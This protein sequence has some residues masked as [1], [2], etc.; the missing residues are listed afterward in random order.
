MEQ[1][2]TGFEPSNHEAAFKAQQNSEAFAQMAHE[3]SQQEN[4]N[5]QE[6]QKPQSSQPKSVS[7]LNAMNMGPKYMSAL[8][9]MLSMAD[10][11]SIETQLP[12]LK[13]T[14]EITPM[15]GQE[16]QAI[17]TAA[18]SPEGF[19][20]K[21][22]ELLFGH[23][24]FKDREFTSYHEFL[25]NLYPPDKSV[26]I[27]ALLTSS[28]MVL[29]TMEKECSE[30]SKT[31]IID[32]TPGELI[33]DDTIEKSWDKPLPPSEYTEV[34]DAI[35]GMLSFEIGM[36]S[37]RDRLVV[38]KLINPSQAK[39]NLENTGGILSYND[40]LAFFSK[41]I[42]V[43][44]EDQPKIVMTDVI[45]DMHPFLSNLPPK[46]TDAVKNNLDLS[47]FD[48]YMPRFYLSTKC[49]HCGASEEVDVDPEVAFF[50][51]AISL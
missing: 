2:N 3:I 13:T 29:P 31:Y 45:N 19:L 11:R 33:H 23:T 25:A 43:E 17:R 8:E 9:S 27:W 10:I 40:N 14:V 28:Y 42:M 36:P 47:V 44:G 48:E 50:R 37:E 26:M 32:S 22:D 38:T 12:I 41:A 49:T 35:P 15:T 30:C 39:E 1:V 4:S 20:K 5:E 18:A 21:L 51:K 6:P 16:E 24:K 46:I 34:Q 7:A